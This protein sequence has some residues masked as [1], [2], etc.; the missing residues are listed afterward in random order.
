MHTYQPTYIP[1]F[2]N[3]VSA[4]FPSPADDYIDKKLDL[5]EYLIK[6]PAAT[7]FIRCNSNAMNG[8]GIYEGDLLIVDKSLNPDHNKIIIAEYDGELIL[9]RLQKTSNGICLVSSNK[10]YATIHIH[11]TEN[12]SVWG[13][14]TNTIHKL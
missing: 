11:K 6:H 9:R 1:L 2:N 12:F 13:I 3:A 10:N 5:N 7:Y 4:G 8:C 14:V